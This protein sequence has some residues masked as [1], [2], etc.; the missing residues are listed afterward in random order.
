[1]IRNPQKKQNKTKNK[2]NMYLYIYIYIFSF[3]A[4]VILP[5]IHRIGLLAQK[6]M[7]STP[8]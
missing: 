5:K 7:N 2:L 8:K 4:R 3:M 1:M 6:H